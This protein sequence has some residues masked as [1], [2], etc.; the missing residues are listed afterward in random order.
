MRTLFFLIQMTAKHG[1]LLVFC[2][3]EPRR[4]SFL[5]YTMVR[6]EL[7]YTGVKVSYEQPYDNIQ[8]VVEHSNFNLRDIR[9]II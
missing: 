8:Q 4:D 9:V 7:N 2:D 6:F 3:S 5:E 1:I